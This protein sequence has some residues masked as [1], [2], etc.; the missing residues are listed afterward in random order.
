MLY[1]ILFNRD[2]N[3]KGGGEL[4]KCSG[5]LLSAKRLSDGEC[6]SHLRTATY[7]CFSWFIVKYTMYFTR[8]IPF[9]MLWKRPHALTLHVT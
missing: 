4:E 6:F 2:E 9:H 8:R 3:I 1:D 7:I 5:R